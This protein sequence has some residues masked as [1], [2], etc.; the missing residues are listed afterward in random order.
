MDDAQKIIRELEEKMHTME[1][2]IQ[3]LR[4][5]NL[6]FEKAVGAIAD[7]FFIVGRDGT[8]LEINK[9]YCDYLGIKRE[10]TIGK[11]ILKVIYNTRMLDIME[12]RTT[13]IDSIHQY[14][15][16]QTAS[17]EKLIA[18][19]RMPV[20]DGDEVIAGVALVKFSRYT[21]TLAN[22]LKKL[23]EEVE[24]YRQ[25]LRRHG[26]NSFSFMEIPCASASCNEARRLAMRFADNDLPLLLL[27]ETGVGKD[28]FAN[29]I[30]QSSKRRNGPFVSVNCASVPADLLESEFFGYAEGAFTGSKKGGRKGKFEM[31]D[32]GTLFLDEIGDM[33]LPLQGKLLRVLQTQ[34]V[35]K[36]GAEKS[37]PVNVRIL[38]A[39]NQDLERKVESKLFRADLFY[40]LNVLTVHIP[41]LRERR[42]D[43]L[44]LSN[45]FLEELNRQYG[46]SVALAPETLFSLTQ[47][48]WPGNVRELRNVIGRGFMITD[49]HQI[50][51]H[52]LPPV[53]FK[54]RE[55][56][57]RPLAGQRSQK[58]R[59]MIVTCL[60]NYKG[61]M[62]KA[63][64]ALGIHRSTLYNKIEDL[65][66]SARE[67]RRQGAAE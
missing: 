57:L 1:A 43:I 12:T 33:P 66:I 11:H 34:E 25:E 51:P 64:K 67:F 42:D 15:D 52:H 7:G 61:N 19:S 46:R 17:G 47:Y 32:G 54:E 26:I 35:E 40:R 55:A 41:P 45:Y 6:I 58:E 20:M 21:I 9:A 2:Q 44:V 23:E 62:T 22:T 28:V 27:G 65:A 29:A 38:A 4:K 31:A 24:F 30:H 8:V 5:R 3:K 63:A 14:V 50:L 49:S 10:E 60:R 18:V 39:T 59:D 36:L 56:G 53:I 13:E 16:G 48:D 37:V